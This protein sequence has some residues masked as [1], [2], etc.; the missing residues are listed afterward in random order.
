MNSSIAKRDISFDSDPPALQ[1]QRSTGG[2]TLDQTETQHDFVW[3]VGIESSTLPHMDVDQFEW[4]G[5]NQRWLADLKLVSEELGLSHLRYAIPWDYMEPEP[6]RF[7]WSVADERIG[8]CGDLGLELMLDVMHFGTPRWL[9]QA[10]GDPEFPEALERLTQAM[11]ERYGQQVH[12]WCP[13]NEPLVTSL[14][15]GDYGF[16]PPHSRKWRGYMPVVSRVAQAT[17]RAIRAIRR[18][19]PEATVLL[20]D[21]AD[22]FNTRDAS[23]AGEVALRN[24]RRFLMLDLISGRVNRHHPLFDW[25]TAY[26]MSELELD[27]FASHPQMADIIGL[28]YYPHS[29]WQLERRENGVRQR[30]ADAPAGL[31]G[32]ANQ[33]YNRYGLPML[34]TETSIEGKPI[35]REVWL[36]R[37]VEDSRS[38]RQ[39]G[40]PLMGMVWWPLFDHLDWDGALT[41]RI[42]KLHEVGLFKLVRQADGQYK[43]LRTPLANAYAA[44][45]ADGNAAVGEMGHL[46]TPVS[47][48]DDQLPPLADF[49]VA[50]D[51]DSNAV[52][53]SLGEVTGTSGF[54][55]S[56]GNSQG[57]L[58]GS[59]N[60]SS[61]GNGTAATPTAPSTTGNT[62]LA[63]GSRDSTGRYG[64]VV[65]SHLR[66]GFVW[67]RPQ[68]FLSRFARK[69]AILFV[70]EPLMDLPADSSP[71]MELHQVMPNVTVACP[72]CPADWNKRTDLTEHLRTW[73]REAIDQVNTRGVFDRPLL[74][75]Y[76]PMD[77]AWSLGCFENRGVIY[78]CMD[79]LSQFTGAPKQLVENERRLIQHADVVFTGGHAL[80]TKKKEQHDNAHF[81][82]CGVEVDHFGLA[83]QD[84]TAIPPDI[85]FVDR[86]IIGWFGVID[87]RVDYHLV[88]EMARLRPDWSFA[89]VGPVVKV[90]PN[91]LPHAPNLY[92]LG[93]RDYAVL[94]N[95][96]RAFDVCMMCFALNDATQYIN[97]TKALEYL[98]TGRPVVSTPVRDVV[99]QYSDLMEIAATP[100]EFVA[101]I[102]RALHS[103]DKDR[104]QRGLEKARNSGWDATVASMQQLIVKGI[105]PDD[106]PSGKPIAPLDHAELS[107]QYASTQGS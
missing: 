103:P 50:G 90:D 92:W 106:R 27:W 61:N 88:G 35:N 24:H 71:R 96:C 86:P 98:A 26:G 63:T 52:R 89:M 45:A 87:E 44:L 46:A 9:G 60:G 95:Y 59:I 56:N 53:K 76:S 70:E 79:E 3:G 13:V 100:Q 42:G 67:Q 16:W 10:V 18:A 37:M 58:N 51:G 83:M 78:D 31:Y 43:R 11:V 39:E 40:V 105:M 2:V 66:W 1:K 14:F 57:N 73:V 38:L 30:R 77:A 32:V 91:L 72:H 47:T 93:G 99:R 81:F 48:V 69:H 21:A 102:E 41:H 19:S 36:E 54:A 6:G 84:S 94:P 34:V 29:D 65:F 74:W 7:D 8:A 101:A 62:A 64:I 68:Q 12:T 82:G 33:Y 17:S 23:L 55:N 4:T 107:V 28:D 15:S 104:I 22:Q 97:P 20:C 49:L 75:Y 80:W 25:V 5:H 85:D